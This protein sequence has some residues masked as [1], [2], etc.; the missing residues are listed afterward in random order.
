MFNFRVNLNT[1]MSLNGQTLSW[2]FLQMM[3]SK[4]LFVRLEKQNSV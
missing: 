1:P 4:N 2:E 3:M